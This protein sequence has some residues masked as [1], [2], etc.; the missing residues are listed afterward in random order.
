MR[1]RKA[2][3]LITTLFLLL[4][5]SMFSIS[6]M[7]QSTQTVSSLSDSLEY[8]KA[9]I[10]LNQIERETHGFLKTIN[11]KKTCN[12]AFSIFNDKYISTATVICLDNNL[13]LV[14]LIVKNSQNNAK[15]SLTK[16]LIQ[17][18]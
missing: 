11:N 7:K 16:R 3:L 9:K 5:I 12:E 14:D 18:L 10:L 2:F 8:S 17:R 15:V 6:F 13:V 4:V 1:S